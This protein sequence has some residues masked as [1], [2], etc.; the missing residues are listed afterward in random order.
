[1]PNTSQ[2]SITIDP[3]APPEWIKPHPG[4]FLREDY[5]AP[6]AMSASELARHLGVPANRVTAI[7]NGNRSISADTA[8]R[9]ARFWNTSA[10]YWMNLQKAHDL[11]KA[12]IENGA[13]IEREVT[14]RKQEDEAA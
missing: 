11:S 1:M 9:L 10:D 14:P 12:W 6:L 8:W 13:R 3:L 5:L 7:L 2:S 4:E